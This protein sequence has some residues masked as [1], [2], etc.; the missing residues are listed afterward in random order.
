M[1]RQRVIG[2]QFRGYLEDGRLIVTIG[3]VGRRCGNNKQWKAYP[4]VPEMACS[5][6]GPFKTRKAAFDALE[7]WWLKRLGVDN[8]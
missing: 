1:I 3:S 8:A 2:K 5:D 7:Q 4:H 6:L